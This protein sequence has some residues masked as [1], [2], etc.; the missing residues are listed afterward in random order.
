MAYF[1]RIRR[2]R[3]RRPYRRYWRRRRFY[4]KRPI[5][6][7][8]RST[9]RVR[10][11]AKELLPLYVFANSR[12]TQV[13]SINPWV[14]NSATNPPAADQIAE[15]QTCCANGVVHTPLYQRFAA[16]YEE[17]KI[18]S[19]HHNITLTAPLANTGAPS[20]TFHTAWDRKTSPAELSHTYNPNAPARAHYPD[21]TTG[22][23]ASFSSHSSAIATSNSIPKIVRSLYANDLL[24]R[25]SY[26]DTDYVT[27]STTNFFGNRAVNAT[28]LQAFW[29]TGTDASPSSPY[30]FTPTFYMQLE[31]P[32]INA[33]NR[34]IPLMVQT[35][36]ICTF[37][38]PKFGQT[39]GGARMQSGVAVRHLPPGDDGADGPGMDEELDG[40]AMQEAHDAAIGIVDEEGVA[41]VLDTANRGLRYAGNLVRNPLDRE[42]WEAVANDI[43]GPGA[44]AVAGNVVRAA[45]AV[46]QAVGLY[47]DIDAAVS[48]GPIH[49]E[50]QARRERLEHANRWPGGSS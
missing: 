39:G 29:P 46:Q 11:T 25:I 47:N 15:L 10:I 48:T 21:W 20:L 44:R 40:V 9:C 4:R 38:N 27:N 31:A 1:R 13:L 19:V 12:Y 30:Y 14:T 23:I 43:G 16:L 2:Y 18:D 7:S 28:R 41:Q 22:E 42:T 3:R 37:R 33:A 45:N 24:E 8:S 50:N 32:D 49:R 6:T 26:V 34:T 17:V 36:Y 35:T 5:N